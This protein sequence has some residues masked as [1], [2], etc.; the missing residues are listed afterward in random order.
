MECES[1]LHIVYSAILYLED[2][3]LTPFENRAKTVIEQIVR[4]LVYLIKR[5]IFLRDDR[6]QII[7][8]TSSTKRRRN[9]CSRLNFANKR[10]VRTLRLNAPLRERLCARIR[11]AARS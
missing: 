3:C 2:R 11:Q 9:A 1:S 4:K 7:Q 5:F 8:R 6:G 10:I